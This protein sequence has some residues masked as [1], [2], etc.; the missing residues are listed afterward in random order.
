MSVKLV[1]MG[2]PLRR[3]RL[4]FLHP[5]D[6]RTKE[7]VCLVSVCGWYSRAELAGAIVSCRRPLPEGTL[8]F[9]SSII[10]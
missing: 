9:H 1:V 7:R 3:S 4:L 2:P 8:V 5:I 10:F 6:G